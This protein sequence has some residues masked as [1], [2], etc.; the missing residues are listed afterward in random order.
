MQHYVI[1]IDAVGGDEP[2]VLCITVAGD[3]RARELARD[4]LH[5]EPDRLSARVMRDGELLFQIS[6]EDQS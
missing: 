5:R 1:H 6:R 2:L 3:L 4:Q